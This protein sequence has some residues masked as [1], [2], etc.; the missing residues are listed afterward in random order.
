MH[1]KGLATCLRYV[2]KD[3]KIFTDTRNLQ[4]C[5]CVCIFFTN[6]NF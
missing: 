3:E 2:G 5:A 4:V 1:N 6:N